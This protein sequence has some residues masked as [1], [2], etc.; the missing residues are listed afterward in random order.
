MPWLRVL[1]LLVFSSVYTQAE[2]LFN[3]H[4]NQ[5]I[6][7]ME[8]E[9]IYRTLT[10]PIVANRKPFTTDRAKPGTLWF[11][12]TDA[13][14][15]LFYPS[16]ISWRRLNSVSS[17]TTL[18][19][20]PAGA[21]AYIQNRSA[22]PPT[23]QSDSTFYTTAGYVQGDFILGLDGLKST[24]TATT[25]QL[26]T[27][28]SITIKALHTD[29]AGTNVAM[30][31]WRNRNTTFGTENSQARMMWSDGSGFSFG[32][33]SNDA[34]TLLTNSVQRMTF[35][36]DGTGIAIGNTTP[37]IT[38]GSHVLEILGAGSTPSNFTALSLS[39][40]DTTA[41]ASVYTRSTFLDSGGSTLWTAGRTGFIKSGS[42]DV[43]FST[44][45]SADYV[46]ETATAAVATEKFRITPLGSVGLSTATPVAAFAVVASSG[47]NGVFLPQRTQAEL[48]TS[49]P[50]VRGVIVQGGFSPYDLWVAT[51]TS[52]G[53]WLNMRTQLGP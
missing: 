37:S 34:L 5:S 13:S 52:P 31:L 9:E 38:A 40:R 22:V 48:L 33:Y 16:S 27:S 53:G 35:G 15:Y 46:I 18:G 1:L 43:S 7:D 14:V 21:T 10:S 23:L 41:N 45:I 19:N 17:M 26:T 3:A 2:Q 8:I 51:L 32:S 44:S 20:L 28:S 29:G 49:T 47:G 36:A 50:V 25:G 12:S 6:T 39:A 24:F 4:P 11:D 30:Q 42:W